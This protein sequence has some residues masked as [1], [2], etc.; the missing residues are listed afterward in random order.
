MRFALP[1]FPVEFEIPDAWWTEAGMSGFTRSG[2]AYRSTADATHT[3]PLRD[4]EPPFQVPEVP[5]GFRGFDRQ[6]MIDVLAGIAAD[7]AVPPVSLLIL[8][9]LADISKAPFPYRVLDGVHRFYASVEAGFEQL[10]AS[11]RECFL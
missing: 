2:P 6:R 3:I 7:K 11:T 10:P 1:M 5:K 4:I 9:A 8:P